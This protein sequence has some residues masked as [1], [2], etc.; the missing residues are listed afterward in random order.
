[1]LDNDSE[2]CNII[3]LSLN[4]DVDSIDPPPL[5]TLKQAKI[6]ANRLY[7]FVVMN[8]EHVEKAGYSSVRNYEAEV[9]AL[10]DA[11]GCMNVTTSIWQPTIAH[12][13]G[14]AP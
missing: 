10:R 7:E 5:L 12:Y 11:I 13:F 2:E 14:S 6:Y 1:M 9:G 4:E 8:K 3:D